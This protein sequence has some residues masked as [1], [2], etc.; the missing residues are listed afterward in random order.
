M[1][2]TAAFPEID[3]TA[4]NVNG[5]HDDDVKSTVGS[6]VSAAKFVDNS[7]HH[8][9]YEIS[10]HSSGRY[11]TV[12]RPSSS[13]FQVTHERLY[14]FEEEE[15]SLLLTHTTAPGVKDDVPVFFTDNRLQTGVIPP[16]ILYTKN[17]KIR[18][19]SITTTSKGS[20]VNLRGLQGKPLDIGSGKMRG[21]QPIDIGLR[22][23]DLV[24]RLFQNKQQSLNSISIGRPFLG[25][26]T[27]EVT[28]YKGASISRHSRR[29]LSANFISDNLPEVIRFIARHDNYMIYCDRFGNFI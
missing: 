4:S 5:G 21:G 13:D 29:F 10:T 2:G 18:P 22:S 8:A 3:D 27:E 9:T 25:P 12:G 20:R 23:T 16:L 26:N 19:H 14:D 17:E 1:A 24:S 28:T 15:E 11:M 7:I 6:K